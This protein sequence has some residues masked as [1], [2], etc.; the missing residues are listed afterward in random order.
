M[1]PDQKVWRYLG[2]FRFMWMLQRRQLWLA[3]ADKLE[4]P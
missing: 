3:R 2:F 1:D 4:D